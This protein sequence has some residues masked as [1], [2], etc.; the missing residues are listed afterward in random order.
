MLE[1]NIAIIHFSNIVFL[2]QV[3]M[4]RRVIKQDMGSCNVLISLFSHI[5]T[6]I[7]MMAR[8]DPI[9]VVL[10]QAW[11]VQYCKIGALYIR[12]VYQIH[13]PVMYRVP[14]HSPEWGDKVDYGIGLSYRPARLHRLA[15]RYDNPICHSRLYPPQ[16][17]YELELY[18]SLYTWR[19]YE[20]GYCTRTLRKSL[21]GKSH[22][23]INVFFGG[24]S[25]VI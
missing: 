2:I 24:V 14:I 20:F 6:Y 9:F 22:H 7:N 16:S 13:S 19:N 11:N 1:R 3:L 12:L 15:G 8:W 23:K 5:K 25:G 17:G 10:W 21:K 4:S 18:K